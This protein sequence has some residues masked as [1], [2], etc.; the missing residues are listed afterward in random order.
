MEAHSYMERVFGWSLQVLVP[1]KSR[2]ILNVFQLYSP[3]PTKTTGFQPDHIGER[4][5]K[6]RKTK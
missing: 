3:G 4:R 5:E 6:K 1:L 2:P